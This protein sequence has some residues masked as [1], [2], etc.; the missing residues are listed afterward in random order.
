MT[1]AKA[2]LFKTAVLTQDVDEYKAGE[3]VAVEY[4]GRGGF[5][6]RFLVSYPGKPSIAVSDSS[7]ADFVL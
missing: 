5:G 2:K 3:V 4:L 7:L 1:I 6:M